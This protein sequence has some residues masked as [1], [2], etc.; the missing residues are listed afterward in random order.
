MKDL[1]TLDY[2]ALLVTAFVLGLTYYV[3]VVKPQDEALN[4]VMEC[5][6]DRSRQEYERCVTRLKEQKHN[7]NLKDT[8]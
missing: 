5:M 1:L 2:L 4:V 8:E 3:F 7:K 6:N